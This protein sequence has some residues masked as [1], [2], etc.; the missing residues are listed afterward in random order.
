MA[1][2]KQAVISSLDNYLNALEEDVTDDEVCKLA[3]SV[4][5]N[6]TEYKNAKSHLWKGIVK[7]IKYDI[8]LSDLSELLIQ[9]YEGIIREDW[10]D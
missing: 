10:K 4:I 9:D 3:K 8:D 7:E 1:S 2:K 6:L 5:G